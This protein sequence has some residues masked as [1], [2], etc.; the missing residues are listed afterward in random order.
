VLTNGYYVIIGSVRGVG[1]GGIVSSA[2]SV[3]FATASFY[4]YNSINLDKIYD[5]I[6]FEFMLMLISI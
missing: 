6:T 4:G 3:S 2:V 5:P 1:A